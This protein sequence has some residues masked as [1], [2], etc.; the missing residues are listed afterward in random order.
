MLFFFDFLRPLLRGPVGMSA[1]FTLFFVT[2][3]VT[4]LVK[5]LYL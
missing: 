1:S 3:N 4:L 5:K 2:L